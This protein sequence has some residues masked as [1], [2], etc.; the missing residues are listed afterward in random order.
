MTT[1]PASGYWENNART[2]GEGKQWGEDIRD[3]IAELLGGSAASMLTIASGVILPITANHTIEGEASASDDLTNITTTNMP[4]G[5]ILL[6]TAYNASHVITVKDA[7][8]GAGQIHLYNGADFALDSTTKWLLLKRVGTDWYE[9]MR[10][11]HTVIQDSD[12]DTKIQVEE[13]DDEDIIRFDTAGTEQITIQDGKIEPST[14]ND[15]DLGSAV[16]E[17]KNLY[18]DGTAELDTANIDAGAINN[19][20]KI[21]SKGMLLGDATGGRVLRIFEVKIED[22]TTANEVRASA[23]NVW[24]GDV[25]SDQDDIGAGETKGNITLSPG[26]TSITFESE[27]L[28]GN[29]IAIVSVAVILNRTT[30]S[31][32]VDAT[33]V[34]NSIQIIFRSEHGLPSLDIRSLVDGDVGEIHIVFAYLTDA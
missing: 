30:T 17:F 13:T 5:R 14:N 9:V 21:D 29:A 32:L 31:L 28:T 11:H 16:K 15:I 10:N 23:A 24:N 19:A 18:I 22:A 34:S 6:I 12:N 2:E 26:G 3:V 1:L 27:G 7:A 25:F 4:D 8:G 33:I 20:V